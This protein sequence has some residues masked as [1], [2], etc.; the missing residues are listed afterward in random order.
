MIIYSRVTEKPD[1]EP[2]ALA[3]VKV[4][5]KVTGTAEDSLITA[6][7]TTAREL[8]EA[9]CGRS[10]ITQERTISLD[11][12][13]SCN[14]ILPYGPVQS[15]DAFTYVD[16]DGNTQALVAGTD[17]YQDL[18]SD[19]A[20][21]RPVESWPMVQ[22]QFNAVSVIYTAGYGDDADDVPAVAKE[23]IYRTIANFFEHRQDEESGTIS[24]LTWGTRMLLNSIRVDW[25]A[26]QD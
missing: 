16:E 25:Y 12:F 21:L 9:D 22:D 14:I 19:I 20:R 24:E 18:E 5:L 6:L 15:V 7:I 4:R 26:W 8:C 10:F 1:V 23:A 13:P 11:R 2:V 3:D 17:F